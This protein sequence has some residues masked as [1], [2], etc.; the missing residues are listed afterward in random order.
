MQKVVGSNPITR[1]IFL[2][3]LTTTLVVFFCQKSCPLHLCSNEH[4]NKLTCFSPFF[5][6]YLDMSKFILLSLFTMHGALLAASLKL[7]VSEE[8]WPPYSFYRNEQHKGIMVEILESLIADEGL[9]LEISFLPEIR[10]NR[11]I[12]QCH[13]DVKPKAKEWV[14][15]AHKYLWS[16]PVVTSQDIIVTT[17]SRPYKNLSELHGKVLGTVRGYTYPKL[18]KLFSSHKVERADAASTHKM[19]E[20]LSKGHTDAAITNSHVLKWY[21]KQYPELAAN[22]KSTAIIVDQAPYRFQFCAAEK[23]KMMLPRLNL[24]LKQL[25]TSGK[26]D[27]ILSRYQ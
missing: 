27:Q 17:I 15:E 19:L 24:R 8:A 5:R 1:S 20:M 25:K 11:E 10:A 3:E 18:E 4:N 12:E 22:L 26:L 13:V 21:Q 16:D 7:D 2:E 9:K 23:W 14:S 6:R